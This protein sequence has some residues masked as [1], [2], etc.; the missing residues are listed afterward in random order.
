M[1]NRMKLVRLF[2]IMNA[3]VA[4][5][6]AVSDDTIEKWFN[7][8]YSDAVHEAMGE[9]GENCEEM[10]VGQMVDYLLEMLLQE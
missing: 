8:K 10:T 1:E 6:D 9:I 2:S 3:A 7:T 4:F 5:E